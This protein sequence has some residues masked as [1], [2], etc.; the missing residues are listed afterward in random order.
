MGSL[1]QPMTPT[2]ETVPDDS[3]TIDDFV[4]SCVRDALIRERVND[5]FFAD[6][7]VFHD[8]GPTDMAENHDEYLYGE[9]A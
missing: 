6:M 8:D 9:K 4:K 3:L 5:P 1:N 7:A 2:A